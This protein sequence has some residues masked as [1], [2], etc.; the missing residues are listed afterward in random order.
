[1]YFKEV[2]LYVKNLKKI[3]WQILRRDFSKKLIIQN[4]LKISKKNIFVTNSMNR[5]LIK[6]VR[7]STSHKKT[8]SLRLYVCTRI[9]E[10]CNPSPNDFPTLCEQ[11]SARFPL[12]E[13]GARRFP[14]LRFDLIFGIASIPIIPTFFA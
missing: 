4:F 3:S 12:K 7:S 11:F 14:L 5:D 1:M 10:P 13:R 9:Y 8:P 2:F 6:N